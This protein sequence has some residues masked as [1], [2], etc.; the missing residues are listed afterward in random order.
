MKK[1]F[2]L[3]ESD[4][5][6]IIKE[7]VHKIL[8]EHNQDVDNYYGGGLPDHYN[9]DDDQPESDY[10][11]IDDIAKIDEYNQKIAD[12]ANNHS[13]DCYDL[14]KAIEIIDDFIEK[15]KQELIKL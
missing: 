4:I 7:C 8:S 12:I 11:S 2:R 6:S 5:H 14:F 3:T 9:D 1:I 13:D 15:K 10:L